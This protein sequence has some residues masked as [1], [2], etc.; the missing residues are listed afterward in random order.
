[1]RNWHGF[2]YTVYGVEFGFTI[3]VVCK[4]DG[5][6]V[7]LGCCVVDFKSSNEFSESQ[8]CKIAEDFLGCIR[9]ELEIKLNIISASVPNVLPL[10]EN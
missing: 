4:V 2:E 7:E 9:F 5:G 8:V 6:K 10:T 3:N 1:M